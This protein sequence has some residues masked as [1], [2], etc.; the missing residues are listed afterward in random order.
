MSLE[1]Q[2]ESGE[3]THTSVQALSHMQWRI[4]KQECFTIL[5]STIWTHL[6]QY[7]PTH[8]HPETLS[9][10]SS[11]L[12]STDH[13]QTLLSVS[14]AR[15]FS[16]WI[17]RARDCFIIPLLLYSLLSLS[18]KIFSQLS[19][20]SV[21]LSVVMC[22]FF[23]SPCVLAPKC[24]G[25]CLNGEGG[26]TAFRWPALEASPEGSLHG[27]SSA[28]VYTSV[29]MS[30]LWL[31]LKSVPDMSSFFWYFEVPS[32]ASASWFYTDQLSLTACDQTQCEL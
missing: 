26:I 32:A 17:C 7:T 18:V 10:L 16:S 30:K 19:A 21:S 1:I 5:A 12:S 6:C 2:Q 22:D 20:L 9:L 8:Q 15:W 23:F 31:W 14:V 3:S 11:C 13:L 27:H 4:T 28:T 24:L 25:D 29:S